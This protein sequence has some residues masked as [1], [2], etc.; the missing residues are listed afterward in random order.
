MDDQ[1]VGRLLVYVDDVIIS[2]TTEVVVKVMELY[3]NK[4]PNEVPSEDASGAAG[5]A[6]ASLTTLDGKNQCFI[7]IRSKMKYTW[8]NDHLGEP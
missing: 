2:G 8:Y 6:M 7:V 4:F 1:I 3:R 5:A